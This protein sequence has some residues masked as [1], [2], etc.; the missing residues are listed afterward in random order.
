M[1]TTWKTHPSLAGLV[2][3]LLLGAP[4][5]AHQAPE[6]PTVTDEEAAE[7]ERRV[8]SQCRLPEDTPT[9]AAP[10]YF[11]YEL[12]LELADRDPARAVE[13]LTEAVRRKPESGRAVRLY[14]MWFRDYL[15]YF[16]LA[17]TQA[18]LGHW[19]CVEDALALSRR[20]GEI[21]PE[22]DEFVELQE[23]EA[24]TRAQGPP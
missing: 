1:T 6:P 13:S 4:G 12:G 8:R 19:R 5:A 3:A 10:W 14:G 11:H 16:Y 21:D 2:L 24:E 7:I 15:P 20:S 22:D 18:A 17:R 9:A 23:L